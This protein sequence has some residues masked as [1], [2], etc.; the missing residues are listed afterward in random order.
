[1]KIGTIG[2]GN[3][4]RSLGILWAEQDHEVFFGSRDSEKGKSVLF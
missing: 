4:A 2:T 1:M 3:M